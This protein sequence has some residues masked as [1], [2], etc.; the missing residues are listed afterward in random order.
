MRADSEP[1]GWLNSLIAA[2]APKCEARPTRQVPPCKKPVTRPT[3]HGVR[4]KL[5]AGQTFRS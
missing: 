3:A 1:L 2:I 4:G 5:V